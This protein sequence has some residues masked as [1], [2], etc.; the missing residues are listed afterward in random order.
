[1]LDLEDRLTFLIVP[2][3]MDVGDLSANHH[4]NQLI[5]IQILNIFG[6]DVFSIPQNGDAVRDLKNLVDLVRDHDNRDLPAFQLFNEGEK[7]LYLPL[8]KRRC[9]LIHND[10]LGVIGD[11]FQDLQHLCFRSG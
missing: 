11:C 1:M 7:L 5:M 2:G 6:A 8:C 3:W 4:G 10:K 9:R